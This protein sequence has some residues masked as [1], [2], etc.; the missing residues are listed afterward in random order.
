MEIANADTS[1]MTLAPASEVVSSALVA[2]EKNRMFTVSGT[3]NYLVSL[4]PRI[5]SRKRAVKIVVDMFKDDVLR[6][7]T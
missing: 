1:K 4:I 5:V 6:K 2:F 3:V 7:S